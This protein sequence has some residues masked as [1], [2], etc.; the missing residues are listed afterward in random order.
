MFDQQKYVLVYGSRNPVA[1]NRSLQLERF[2]VG[3]P[4]EGYGP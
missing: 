4:A 2:R 1:R 3:N